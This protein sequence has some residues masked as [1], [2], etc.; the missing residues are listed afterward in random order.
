M[1]IPHIFYIEPLHQNLM[2]IKYIFSTDPTHIFNSAYIF[3]VIP[4]LLVMSYCHGVQYFVI[5]LF[6]F[7]G[8][9]V[10]AKDSRWLTPLHR[11]CASGSEVSKFLNHAWNG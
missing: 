6:Y 1:T 10:N 11:A 2:M 7:T 4:Q 8:A 3:L 9:K 5:L